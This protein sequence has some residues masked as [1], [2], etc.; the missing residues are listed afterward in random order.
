MRLGGISTANKKNALIE[1]QKALK[2]NGFN[3]FLIGIFGIL[4]KGILYLKS[5]N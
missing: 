4:K 3:K 1:Y 5:N 2:K